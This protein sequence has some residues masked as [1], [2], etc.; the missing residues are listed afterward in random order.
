V[1]TA[2]PIENDSV[3]PLLSVIVRLVVEIVAMLPTIGL[4]FAL[5]EL[6]V[7]VDEPPP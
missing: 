1:L 6:P 2:A 4:F 3:T 7:V 5:V